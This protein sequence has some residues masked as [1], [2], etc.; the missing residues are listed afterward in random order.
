VQV[1]LHE[2]KNDIREKQNSMEVMQG[3]ASEDTT[4][5][6]VNKVYKEGEPRREDYASIMAFTRAK[7]AWTRRQPTSIIQNTGVSNNESK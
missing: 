6:L 2:F 4:P 3:L 5:A 1:V 7:L